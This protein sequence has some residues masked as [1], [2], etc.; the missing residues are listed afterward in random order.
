MP[1]F[2]RLALLTALATGATAWLYLRYNPTPTVYA[3]TFLAVVGLSALAAALVPWRSLTLGLLAFA[4]GACLAF[5]M[6]TVSWFGFVL[7][8]LA[9]LAS[10]TIVRMMAKRPEPRR[11]GVALLG[12][13][14]AG[15]AFLAVLFVFAGTTARG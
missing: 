9:L 13:G 2:W 12:G 10:V 7:L 5:G 4:T 3:L 14:L 15:L 8:G 1:T 6:V 11:A